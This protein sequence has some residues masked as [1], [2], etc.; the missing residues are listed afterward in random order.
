MIEETLGGSLRH[1]RETQGITLR[2]L[3]EKADISPSF[4]SQI[5]NGQCSPSISSMERI[6]NVLGM[7]LGQFFLSANQQPVHIVRAA[8]RT[9]VPL[10][11]SKAEISPLGAL[12]NGSQLQASMVS[13]KPAGLTGKHPT[14]SI[15]D[16]FAIV[17][18]GTAILRLQKDEHTLDRGDAVTLV[19]GTHRQ[20]RNETASPVQILVMSLPA[21]DAK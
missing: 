17:F 19:A 12:K 1:V 4:L 3:A 20:W 16:E 8:Q 14:P 6:V 21:S 5:E 9:Q 11:W 15:S 7:T 13:I 18:E 2:A 10:D